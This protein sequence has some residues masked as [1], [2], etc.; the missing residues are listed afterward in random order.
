MRGVWFEAT[1]RL[2]LKSSGRMRSEF[3]VMDNGLV[4]T[5]VEALP[6]RSSLA[7]SSEYKKIHG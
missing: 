4:K 1:V 2:H 3:F 6:Y 5:I 7:L